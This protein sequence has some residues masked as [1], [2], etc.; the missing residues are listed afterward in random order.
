MRCVTNRVFLA[1][2]FE[3]RD[4][5]LKGSRQQAEQRCRATEQESKT[6]Q[7]SAPQILKM[8]ASGLRVSLGHPNIEE[9]CEPT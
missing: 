6:S 2:G 8:K 5:S 3:K 1:A 4:A 7:S 9:T